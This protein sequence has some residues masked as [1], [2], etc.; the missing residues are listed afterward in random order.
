MK[1]FILLLASFAMVSQ[2]PNIDRL[3]AGGVKFSQFYNCGKCEPSRAALVPFERGFH[4]H[5]GFLGGGTDYFRGD[6]SFTLDGKPWPVPAQGFYVTTA[7]TDH[8]VQFMREEQAANPG[9]P[10]FL[11]LAYNAPHSS[12]QAPA[13]VVVKNRGKYRKG[14]DVIQRERFEK[15]KALGLAGPGWSFPER[16]ASLPAWDSLDEKNRDFEDLR[17]ATYAAMVDCVDQGVGRVMQTLDELKILDNTLVI[18]FNDNGASPNDRARRGA[19]GT[20]DSNWNVGLGWTHASN[21][22]FKFYKRSQHSGGVTTPFIA[23]WPA[24]IKPRA[25]FEDQP[26]HVID[27]LPTLIEI[28]EGKYPADFGGKQHPPLPGRSFAPIL[29]RG[30][31]L[32]PRTLHFA[33]FNNLALIHDGW[34]TKP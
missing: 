27:L 24:A 10:F 14:W 34:K 30:E 26:C 11:Y 3:A 20:P 1:T 7:L 19:F 15:Q 21:T 23:H 28:G 2:S 25:A 12:L 29:T 13:D 4:R 5:F 33:P 16:P 17:M 31:S 22:P 8:A 6:G 18:F 32:A 9:K